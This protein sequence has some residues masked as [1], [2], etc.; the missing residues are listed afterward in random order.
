MGSWWWSE[1][2][3]TGRLV[4]WWG[5]KN[6]RRLVEWM[7][8]VQPLDGLEEILADVAAGKKSPAEAAREI[9]QAAAR[10][11]IPVWFP[12]VFPIGGFFF[13]LIGC[14]FAVYS[15]SFSRGTQRAA[16]TVIQLANGSPIVAYTV[17]N[18]QFEYRSLI[19]SSPPSY[20]VGDKVDVLCRLADPATA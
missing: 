10:P 6:M 13:T 15:L 3:V 19:S 14:G 4:D 11:H 9:R 1:G 8:L 18:R 16:G 20:V 12:R 2:G 7:G 17:G 5:R